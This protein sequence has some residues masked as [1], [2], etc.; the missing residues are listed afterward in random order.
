MALAKRGNRL[1]LLN[2]APDT[3]L[4]TV[5]A[6]T[7]LELLLGSLPGLIAFHVSASIAECVSIC[8]FGTRDAVKFGWP[9]FRRCQACRGIQKK[10]KVF[11]K[12]KS[13]SGMEHPNPTLLGQAAVFLRGCGCL[14][15]P[16]HPGREEQAAILPGA[17]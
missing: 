8:T 9:F 11:Q 5:S 1:L 10:M 6:F 17:T 16:C 7:N 15:R 2:R 4:L 14:A 12:Q 13:V 3:R